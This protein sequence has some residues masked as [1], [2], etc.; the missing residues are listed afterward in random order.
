[1]TGPGI[2][3]SRL[4]SVAHLDAIRLRQAE[5]GTR[6]VWCHKLSLQLGADSALAL[7]TLA[8]MQGL[9]AC[10]T[11]PAHINDAD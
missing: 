9:L 2:L 4:F 8:T 1:M 7:E 3:G 6:I 11:V 10:N 5:R